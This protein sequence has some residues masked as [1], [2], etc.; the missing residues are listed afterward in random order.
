MK[1]YFDTNIDKTKHMIIN[2][3]T[4]G[5]I[6]ITNNSNTNNLEKFDYYKYLALSSITSPYNLTTNLTMTNNGRK[7]A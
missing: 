3:S 2:Q 5:Q 1:L 6:N 7:T 4:T